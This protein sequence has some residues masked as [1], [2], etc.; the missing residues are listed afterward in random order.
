M[1]MEKRWQIAKQ[2]PKEFF[3]SFLE[4]H[5]II[6]QLLYNRGLR[7]KEQ[8]EGFLN[9]DWETGQH[10]PFLMKGV[11]KAVSEILKAIK[12]KKKI[13]LFAHFDVDGIT[14]A[15]LLFSV[16]KHFGREPM[17]YIPERSEG[18]GLTQAALA[19]FKK[20]QIGLVITADIGISSQKEV[21]QAEKEGMKV[22]ICDHHKVPRLL[23]PATAILNPQQKDCPYPFK[24]LAGVGVVFKLAE[25]L[26]QTKKELFHP[27]KLKWLVDL[28][29]L[30]TICDVV[31]LIDENRLFAKFGLIVLRKTKNLGLKKLFEVCQLKPEEIN[32]STSSFIIGP[33]LNAPGR[34][35][36]ANASFYLLVAKNPL[37]AQ[38]LALWLHQQNQKRQRLL[39]QAVAQAKEK[40][41]NEGWLDK[42]VIVVGQ[43]DWPTG[44]I[45]LIASRLVN[46]Y[47]R[48]AFVLQIG[49]KESKGSVRSIDQFH[50]VEALEAVG[51]YLLQFGGHQKAG[52][53]SILTERLEELKRELL[54]LAEKKLTEE[55]IKP[56]IKIDSKITLSQINWEL[57][58]E[59]EKFEPTGFGN[60]EPVFLMERVPVTA[61]K[62]VGKDLQHL[63]FLFQGLEGIMFNGGEKRK[64]QPGELLDL[65]F[66]L[67]VDEWQA[68]RKLQLKILDFKKSE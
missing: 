41:E 36:H 39:E 18:Y 51:H 61:V 9:P 30:G 56:Q 48:P 37:Y 5:P 63:K 19:E 67:Q 35:D 24:E 32:V 23:P 42:R 59:L 20:A 49:Q 26:V 50:V 22:I 64:V 8:I 6:L 47:S 44:I 27:Q 43:E 33:R 60:P 55:D 58:E 21:A 68:R 65:V 14:S 12:A 10:D 45:G 29:G 25:A 54:R 57:W 31:P 46:E 2:A 34:M 62:T 1:G 4:F 3:E 7:T 11:R 13:A 15:A 52:G 40:I 28:V 53:F 66:Q 16:F 38:K 17:V